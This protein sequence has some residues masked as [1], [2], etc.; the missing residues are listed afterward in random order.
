[1]AVVLPFCVTSRVRPG[2]W[3]PWG[4]ISG[5]V[6][7]EA[8]KQATNTSELESKDI[9]SGG[10]LCFMALLKQVVHGQYNVDRIDLMQG[11]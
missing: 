3:E 1:M 2:R 5:A 6:N 11:V 8:G 10:E 9:V 4:P 7:K